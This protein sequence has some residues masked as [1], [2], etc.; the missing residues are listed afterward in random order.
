[1]PCALFPA[2]ACDTK[3]LAGSE[4]SLTSGP[5]VV[6]VVTVVSVVAA[7]VV[8]GYERSPFADDEDAEAPAPGGGGGAAFPLRLR[9]L[10]A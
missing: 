5:V 2:D 6:T 7:V 1:M 3:S 4:P 10:S 9:C 8:S